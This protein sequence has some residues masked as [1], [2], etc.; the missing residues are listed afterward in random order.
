[1][2]DKQLFDRFL[3]NEC[4]AEEKKLVL[5]Y[6]DAHPEIVA[7]FLPEE[8]FK[9]TEPVSWQPAHSERTFRLIRQRT[10]PGTT[11]ILKWGLVA[12]AVVTCA[13]IG[14]KWLTPVQKNDRV[15][16]T[17]NPEKRIE[18]VTIRN[19][20]TKTQIL[21]L[22]DGST[23]ELTPG[24]QIEYQS[25]FAGDDK[26]IVR[27]EGEGQFSVAKDEKR[28]F[29][30]ISGELATT[31]LGT[32]FSV[33]A[34][35]ASVLVKVHLYSGKVRIEAA[36]AVKWKTKDS[37]FFLSPGQ[38]LTYNKQQMLAVVRTPAELRRKDRLAGATGKPQPT[39]KNRQLEASQKPDWYMFGGQPLSEVFDQ[40]SDY[41][42]V[43]INYF[44]SDVANRY[45]TGKFSKNDSLDQILKDISLLHGL[46]LKKV[47]GI[48][49]FRKKDQ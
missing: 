24:S 47:D 27:L 4:N 45:F 49:V 29:T 6:L 40:L 10:N 19:N 17:G 1:M 21:N 20:W 5:D 34:D 30:V 23:A 43:Q 32:Y 15:T 3:R 18:W 8:E 2:I 44:S 42:G 13:L 26:R 28:P 31:A 14:I 35:P 9:E 11:V 39:Q 37:A 48:Y 7:D 12:A 41:Y 36:G 22:P 33:I 46:T 16:Q 25:S 38:E